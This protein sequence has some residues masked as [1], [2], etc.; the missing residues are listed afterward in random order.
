MARIAT[1]TPKAVFMGRLARGSEL[2]DGLTAVCV[3]QGVRLGRVLA[4]GAVDGPVLE[5]VPDAE[6]GLPLWPNQD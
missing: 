6:T 5:R 4:V 3:K 2:L 1:L